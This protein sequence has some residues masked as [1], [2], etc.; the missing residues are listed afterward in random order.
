MNTDGPIHCWKDGKAIK[1]ILSKVSD[2]QNYI[3]ATA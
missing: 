3:V 1:Y 2:L